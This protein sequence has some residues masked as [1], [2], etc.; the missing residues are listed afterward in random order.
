M[1]KSNEVE[2][3]TVP[4]SSLETL[5]R[6]LYNLEQIESQLPEFLS[7][8]DPDLLSQLPLL[9]RAQS[10]FTLAKLTSTLFSCSYFKSTPS[11]FYFKNHNFI[12][13]ISFICCWVISILI[14]IFHFVVFI[15]K[16]KCRGINP[17]DHAFKSELVS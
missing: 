1:V 8:S 3:V 13:I 2:G 5:N 7:N 11:T 17:N 12:L 9:Q 10:L 16:L 6:T 14:L 15:V 4:E